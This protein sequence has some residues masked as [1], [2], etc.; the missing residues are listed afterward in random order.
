M[1]Q[2]PICLIG[3]SRRDALLRHQR[4]VH[5]S[6]ERDKLKRH[7]VHQD[8]RM[9]LAKKPRYDTD[10]N[11]KDTDLSSEPVRQEYWTTENEPDASAYSDMDDSP[12]PSI[13]SP[14]SD[15]ITDIQSDE[16]MDEDE[17]E[18]DS[19]DE[20]EDSTCDVYLRN[21]IVPRINHECRVLVIEKSQ[22]HIEKGDDA[23]TAECKAINENLHEFRQ[24]A[25]DVL[26]DML[27]NIIIVSRSPLYRSIMNTVK[28]LR[29]HVSSD[30]AV[31]E[32]LNKHKSV[33][34]PL[35]IPEKKKNNVRRRL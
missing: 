15:D 23:T 18:E 19:E 24:R 4:N 26:A 3:F 8:Q 2:C 34:G 13:R 6:N 32:T 7:I 12:E 5:S 30:V 9:D 35:L 10:E 17:E 28:G 14:W 31:K 22:P 29:E 21:L 25:I 16:E 1:N 27:S 20:Q 11:S 33:L